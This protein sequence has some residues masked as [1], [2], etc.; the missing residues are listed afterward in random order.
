MS[1]LRWVGGLAVL[2]SMTLAGCGS[3]SGIKEGAP[4]SIDMSKDY[5]PPVKVGPI[6]P[7]DM[8]GATAGK[9]GG[10]PV[11]APLPKTK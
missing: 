1:H 3:A 10:A 5:S 8:A 6:T 9:T 2:S 7:K 11:G 4:A